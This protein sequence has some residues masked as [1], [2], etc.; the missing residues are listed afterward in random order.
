VCMEKAITMY[1]IIMALYLYI[2][3]AFSMHTYSFYGHLLTS[4]R[5]KTYLFNK[6]TLSTHYILVNN[7]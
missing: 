1:L 4:L 7:V 5:Y 3:I 2:V 6:I